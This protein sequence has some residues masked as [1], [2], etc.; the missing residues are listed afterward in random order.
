MKFIR[1][2]AFQT[3]DLPPPSKD[4]QKEALR[5]D[6]SPSHNIIILSSLHGRSTLSLVFLLFPTSSQSNVELCLTAN[7]SL[8]LQRTKRITW[9]DSQK[10]VSCLA[11]TGAVK[12]SSGQ[13]RTSPAR[14]TFSYQGLKH[15]NFYLRDAQHLATE[16]VRD[17]Q[18]KRKV[19][20]N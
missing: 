11:A 20:I 19:R 18:W 7:S 5:L 13:G 1:P 12:A 10:E 4:K 2:N 6:F 17:V 9:V 16:F 8:K 3:S 15:W 14:V